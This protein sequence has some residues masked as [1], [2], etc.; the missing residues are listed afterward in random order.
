MLT[1]GLPSFAF[2]FS[3]EKNARDGNGMSR[4]CLP[5]ASSKLISGYNQL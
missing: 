3:E 5:E 2:L 1:E 4:K